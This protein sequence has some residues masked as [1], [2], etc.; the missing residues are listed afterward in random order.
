MD[1]LLEAEIKKLKN[2]IIRKKMKEHSEK[3]RQ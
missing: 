3:I 1:S 2:D